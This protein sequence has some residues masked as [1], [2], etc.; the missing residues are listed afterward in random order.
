MTSLIPV[1][2]VTDMT[3]Y[4]SVC[5][6]VADPNSNIARNLERAKTI[7]ADNDAVIAQWMSLG[8]SR[9]EAYQAALFGFRK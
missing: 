4:R 5:D 6:A 1:I 2:K 8:Y 7:K 9:D 3:T